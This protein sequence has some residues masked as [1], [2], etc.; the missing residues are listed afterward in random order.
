[1]ARLPVPGAD[2]NVWGEVLNE[3]LR[4]AHNDDGTLKDGSVGMGQL[5]SSVQSAIDAALVESTLDKQWLVAGPINVAAGDVDYIAPAYVVV[6][7]G[8]TAIITAVRARISSGTNVNMR[9]TQNGSTIGSLSSITVTPAGVSLTGLS[10]PVADADLLAPV[11][12][13]TSGGPQNLTFMLSYK[14]TKA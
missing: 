8:H 1:M 7:A 2:T 5:A 11:V 4:Q 9:V 3:F 6:P 14:I 10:I 12:N 13:S